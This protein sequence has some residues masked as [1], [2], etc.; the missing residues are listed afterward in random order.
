MSAVEGEDRLRVVVAEDDPL[1]RNALC[2]TLSTLGGAEIVAEA[3]SGDAAVAAAGRQQP[4]VVVM[5][6]RM[7]GLDGIEATRRIVQAD[8]DVAVLMLSM[9]E[10]D[11]SV[12]AAMRAGARG[13]IVKGADEVEIVGAVK[14]VARGEAIFSAAVAQRILRFFAN[15]G[16]RSTGPSA[17]FP[18]LTQR[19]L[20]I[21]EL[22][23]G[24]QNNAVIASRLFLSPKT[25]RNNV[26]N[27]FTKLQVADRAEAIVRA[28][29]AGLGGSTDMPTA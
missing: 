8:P 3:G 26:S 17:A 21:L 14:A 16:G 5:D 28:R 7:P 2:T 27:I 13:Y 24:G 1:Y 15:A 12:F 10:D 6:I 11:D 4:Q 19:E 18:E 20:E 23:A 25:V 9:F 29:E 22:I